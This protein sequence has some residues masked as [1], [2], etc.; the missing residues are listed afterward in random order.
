[1]SVVPC[2]RGYAIICRNDTY[3]RNVILSISP[4]GRNAE[5]RMDVG[6]TEIVTYY[7]TKTHHWMTWGSLCSVHSNAES[8]D[9]KTRCLPKPR[10]SFLF[11]FFFSASQQIKR[12]SITI[13]VI[14]VVNFVSRMRGEL[15]VCVF[16]GDGVNR[17]AVSH[18]WYACDTMFVF[19]CVCVCVCVFLCVWQCVREHVYKWLSLAVVCVCLCVFVC[20]CVCLHTANFSAWWTVR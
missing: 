9:T 16:V 10:M 6:D 4:R 5:S 14:S 11:V 17:V 12:K 1:M 3:I 15:C 20:V 13:A 2:S 7:K 18:H 8:K 19:V